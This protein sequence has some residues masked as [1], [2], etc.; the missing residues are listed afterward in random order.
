MSEFLITD[1]TEYNGGYSWFRRVGRLLE[2]KSQ[3]RFPSLPAGIKETTSLLGSTHVGNDGLYYQ[4]YEV[5]GWE[6]EVMFGKKDPKFPSEL[7]RLLDAANEGRKAMQELHKKYANKVEYPTGRR[8]AAVTHSRSLESIYAPLR[9]AKEPESFEINYIERS[10]LRP[11]TSPKQAT[12]TID[13]EKVMIGC[14][15]FRLHKL[16]SA[17]DK[18]LH[19]GEFEVHSLPSSAHASFTGP[20]YVGYCISWDT[21]KMLFE[22]LKCKQ[23]GNRLDDVERKYSDVFEEE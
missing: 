9:L 18:L 5:K 4:S 2:I 13:G 6:S 23:V 21:A 1:W 19:R 10:G 22:K 8:M 15:R 14:Q 7:Q 3:V 17:L 11:D 16:V 20:V 12:V